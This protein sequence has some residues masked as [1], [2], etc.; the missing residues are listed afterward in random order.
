[1]KLRVNLNGYIKGVQKILEE[2]RGVEKA[3]LNA[4]L[5]LEYSVEEFG[6]LLKFQKEML[7]ELKQFIVD[8]QSTLNGEDSK[9][10][11]ELEKEN[12][13]LIGENCKLRSYLRRERSFNNTPNEPPQTQ[14]PT[15]Q[16]FRDRLSRNKK[17]VER[18]QK[19]AEN[20]F[21]S[22]WGKE[23]NEDD[24]DDLY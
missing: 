15:Q 19:E 14:G 21:K 18:L 9:D 7:P 13:R 12:E 22:T 16:S 11:S 6:A 24:E 4:N 20:L 5:G 17:S 8:V 23:S 3:S 2:S 1:M 10:S